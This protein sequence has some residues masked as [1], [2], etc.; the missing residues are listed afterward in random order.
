MSLLCCCRVFFYTK[1]GRNN[2]GR[3]LLNDY[4]SHERAQSG[5]LIWNY[6]LIKKEGKHVVFPAYHIVELHTECAVTKD[7]S[8]VDMAHEIVDIARRFPLLIFGEM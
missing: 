5:S 7:Y 1:I 4:R 2:A 6:L 3:S 8:N